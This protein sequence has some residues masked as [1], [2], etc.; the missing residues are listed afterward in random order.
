MYKPCALFRTQLDVQSRN[1]LVLT[2]PGSRPRKSGLLPFQISSS[3]FRRGCR[4]SLRPAAKTSSTYPHRPRTL[5]DAC[6]LQKQRHQVDHPRLVDARSVDAGHMELG[7][8]TKGSGAMCSVLDC[9]LL[10]RWRK[11]RRKKSCLW[12]LPIA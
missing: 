2:S 8:Q 12:L 4:I 5:L 11:Q 9:I 3:R 10:L 7:Q 6:V 1:R